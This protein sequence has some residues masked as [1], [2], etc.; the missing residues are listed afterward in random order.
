M[1]VRDD[2]YRVFLRAY[3][4]L[5]RRAR[6]WAVRLGTPNYTVGAICIVVRD[7]GK[8]LL[9]RHSYWSRWGTPGG[10]A[11]RG[12][13][14]EV[15]AVRETK[16][17]VNL[18]VV[19]VGEPAVVVEPG[20]HRVDVVFLCRP[21]AD[22]DLRAVRPSSPEILGLDWFDF[23][24]LPELHPETASAIVALERAGR[25]AQIPRDG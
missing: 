25:L 10:L 8:V 16:E 12:E 13:R 11:Q 17:E 15:A 9:V 1:S 21:R 4:F 20:P 19:V 23:S 6:R 14:P 18:D 24:D 3:R 5:P 22:A 7:D 2:A